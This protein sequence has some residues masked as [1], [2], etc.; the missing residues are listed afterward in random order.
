MTD[1]L[2]FLAPVNPMG[3]GGGSFATHAYLRAFSELWEGKVDVLLADSWKDKWD[4]QIKIDK[5]YTAMPMT[6]VQ[7][8][9]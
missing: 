7:Y 8:A 1:K 9:L 5:K 2:L 6:K 3:I 4:E